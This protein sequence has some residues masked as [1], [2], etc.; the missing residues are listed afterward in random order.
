MFFEAGG[1]G[2]EVHEQ[3][4]LKVPASAVW[5]KGLRRV[6]E[7][8]FD[9]IPEAIAVGAE[10]RDIDRPGMGLTFARVPRAAKVL[11][12]ASLS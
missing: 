8:A 12:Q 11:R 2:S 9:Q 1:D 4:R 10:G 5:W 7:E 6:V 3:S